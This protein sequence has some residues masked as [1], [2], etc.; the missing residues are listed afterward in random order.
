M[1]KFLECV[2][3]NRLEV[4]ISE[5]S[6]LSRGQYGFRLGVSTSDAVQKVKEVEV[7]AINP[8]SSEEKV[9]A[10]HSS[11]VKN[12][13][14]QNRG[15]F[16]K[17][18]CFKCGKHGHFGRDCRASKITLPTAGSR[19][20][21]VEKYYN[22]CKKAGHF[23][24]NCWALNDKKNRKYPGKKS[25]DTSHKKQN[26]KQTQSDNSDSFENEDR[27]NKKKKAITMAELQI[28]EVNATQAGLD[29]VK[30]PIQETKREKAELL[31]DTEASVSL[32]KK[33]CLKGKTPAEL[34]SVELTGVTGQ[35]LCDRKLYGNHPKY[36]V[37]HDYK[38]GK[39]LV[40]QKTLALQPYKNVEIPSR[41]E[42]IIQAVADS[43]QVG[44]IKAEE[45]QPETLIGNC[46]VQPKNYLCPVNIINTMEQTVKLQIQQIK[47]KPLTDI[48]GSLGINIVENGEPPSKTNTVRH[49]IS[50]RADTAPINVRLYRL[51]EKHKIEVDK[52]IKEMLENETIRPSK[53]VDFRRLND[54]TIGDSFPLPNITEILDQ[55][56][57]AKYFSTLDLASGYHQIPIEETDKCKTAFLKPYEHSEYNRM[58]FGLKNAPATFQRLM[59]SVLSGLQSM[60]CF[61]Y[62]DDIVI[63][64]ASLEEH[65]KRL[66]DVVKD[67]QAFIG[68]AGYYRKFIDQFSRIA[69]S[70]TQ[71]T[72]KG[73]NFE[74]VQEQQQAFEILKEK[75]THQVTQSE[76]SC[77]KVRYDKINLSHMQAKY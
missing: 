11:Q 63:H 40:E 24:E 43:N 61:I 57:N 4:I 18:T 7:P 39:I 5:G 25:K 51:P 19:M 66:K 10:P 17:N 70:L 36:N 71:L 27:S 32:I 56:G 75:P 46:L 47:V 49:Q 30:L 53:I 22:Y 15:K 77:R 3:A 45:K 62:L 76:L 54:V 16:N 35:S 20:N 13:N 59:N 64:G 37:T 31:Y 69:K 41:C 29:V 55:L 50:V 6:G 52:Q 14:P 74:W 21:T 2:I 72:R 60:K 38:K 67:I 58:P 34:T 33:K 12:Q 65:R 9:T 44:L 68:L 42:A 26:K 73:V 23:R 1:G 48:D 8:A 28:T